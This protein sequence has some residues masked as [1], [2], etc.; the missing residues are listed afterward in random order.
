MSSEP[1]A[2]RAAPP[3]TMTRPS[4]GGRW[5]HVDILAVLALAATLRLVW[6]PLLP[7][8]AGDEGAWAD[9]AQHLYRGQPFE[10]ITGSGYASPIYPRLLALAMHA[11]GPSFFAA[12]VLTAL[13]G[14]GGVALVY[15][16]VR[17][18]GPRA[19]LVAAAIL[20]VHPTHVAWSRTA[21]VPYVLQSTVGL[22]GVLLLVAS[23]ERSW[24]RHAAGVLVLA[25]GFHFGP[26]HV[27]TA[28]AV[29]LT[30]LATG[31][32]RRL[33][34]PAVLLSLLAGGLL[35][36]QLLVYDAAQ[37]G[38]SHESG[39]GGSATA[40]LLAYG[41]RFLF[42]LSG[43]W[44]LCH[45][46]AV[47]PP[48]I[49]VAG[50]LV[51][52]AV[53]VVGLRA[54]V[55]GATA[56]L[57]RLALAQLGCLL[58]VLP[59]LLR[60]KGLDWTLSGI[61]RDRYLITGVPFFAMAAG[62]AFARAGAAEQQDRAGAGQS[63]VAHFL[64]GGWCIFLLLHLVTFFFA[65]NLW[66]GG[67]DAGRSADEGAGYRGW[68][69]A[70]GDLPLVEQLAR[71]LPGVGPVGAPGPPVH[72]IAAD[73]A[74]VWPL[75]FFLDGTNADVAALEE[76]RSPQPPP[77]RVCLVAFADAAFTP[78][79]RETPPAWLNRA[80]WSIAA[81]LP[82]PQPVALLHARDGTALA[83]VVC[84]LVR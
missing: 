42:G 37:G 84:A 77:G 56:R 3:P 76:V 59:L 68:R 25:L 64:I 12:R 15:L 41:R 7:A 61:D 5:G 40:A 43:A 13:A 28:A 62:Y 20:A 52:A 63:G 19:A 80:A 79:A 16:L 8:P 26:L 53:L 34:H 6:L 54:A 24:W 2:S 71:A 82:D 78:A 18:A 11:L 36:A 81:R 14:V 35:L 17:E 60:F 1:P 49:H 75:R 55:R 48:G 83:G 73:H 69:V 51:G 32:W 27:A 33:L 38:T 46:T 39:P 23:S 57:P 50:A 30:L 66:R 70:A 74:L 72:V 21:A 31:T 45:F 44:S 65:H 47:R 67:P 10:P 58:V 29:G 4:P 22:A 9:Y